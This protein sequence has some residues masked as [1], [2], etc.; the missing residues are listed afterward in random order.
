[1]GWQNVPY[2]PSRAV[3]ASYSFGVANQQIPFH[4]DRVTPQTTTGLTPAEH[5]MGRMLR[6]HLDLL[7]PDTLHQIID[8]QNKQKLSPPTT[9]KKFAI[10]DKL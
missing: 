3:S 10:G 4:V 9:V 2:R 8:K 5:L 7:H 6:T 1:M